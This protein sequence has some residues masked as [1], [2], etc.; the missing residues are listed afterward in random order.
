MRTFVLG[1]TGGVGRL[2]REDL[3]ARGDEVTGLVRRADQRAQLAAGG[4]TTVG[5]DLAEITPTRLAEAVSGSDAIVFTAGSNGGRRAVT[6]AVDLAGLA[7]TVEAARLAGVDRLV[8][9]SVLPEADRALVLDADVEHYFAVKKQA[10]IALSRT[11]LDWL[12]LRPSMLVDEPG[13]GT[14]DLGPAAPHGRVARA[15]VAATV[16]E[17]LHAPDVSREV[18]ELDQGSTPVRDAVRRLPRRG[19]VRRDVMPGG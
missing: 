2:L 4:V 3:L 13:R 18:L 5:G 10:D 17:L 1:L 14:V 15:D 8:S 6:D 11:E 19:R 16:A 7:T 12:I 9:V